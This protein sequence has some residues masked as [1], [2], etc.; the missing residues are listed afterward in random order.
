MTSAALMEVAA[1]TAQAAEKQV[2]RL[3]SS[4]K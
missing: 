3:I 2:V 1:S 4:S